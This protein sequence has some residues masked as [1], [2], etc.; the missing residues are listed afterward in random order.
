LKDGIKG[1][2]RQDCLGLK[3]AVDMLLNI[4]LE[5][6]KHAQVVHVNTSL[7]M[8]ILSILLGIF[9]WIDL[10]ET[11]FSLLYIFCQILLPVLVTANLYPSQK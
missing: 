7:K 3:K 5:N 4:G 6:N 10:V 2:D 11:C 8:T 9:Y 1:Y